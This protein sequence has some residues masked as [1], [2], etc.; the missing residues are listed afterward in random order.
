MAGFKTTPLQ[1]L[2]VHDLSKFRPD[3]WMPYKRYFDGP[4][5]P[6][7]CSGEHGPRCEAAFERG[8]IKQD[9]LDACRRHYS[10]NPHHW[11]YWTGED[12]RP[13]RM[14]YNFITEMVADWWGAGRAISGRWEAHEW[15]SNN[16]D[17]IQ[18]HPTT[19]HD[20][21]V[22]MAGAQEKRAA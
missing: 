4:Y 16:Y 8:R 15:Y 5:P 9:F 7:T 14:P 22:L 21:D 12:G 11:Q 13:T 17:K 18:L 20:V 3:E 10:R 19:R 6:C 2:L 1:Q